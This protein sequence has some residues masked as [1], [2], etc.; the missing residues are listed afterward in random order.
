MTRPVTAGLEQEE[1]NPPVRAI[2]A[3]AKGEPAVLT[4]VES[5]TAAVGEVLVQVTHS[6][7]NYKDGAALLGRPGI[8]RTW[9][10]ILG[11]DAVGIVEESASD[12]FAVGDR[13]VLNGAGAGEI[14][15][16]GFAERLAAPAESLVHVPEGLSLSQAAAIGTAGFTAAIAVLAIEDHGTTPEDGEVLVT[17]AAGGVGSVAISLLAGRG[18]RVV[19]STGRAETEGDYLT[20]LGASRIIDR[21]G[22]SEPSRAPLG[23]RLWSAVVDGVGSHTLVN[24]VAQLTYGGIAVSYGLAQGADLPGTVMPFILRAATLTGANSVDAPLALRQRAWTMLGSQLDLA[25]LDKMTATVGLSDTLSLAGPI[26]A[27]QVRGRTV[28]DLSS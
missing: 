22:L 23:Q 5:P 12:R 25:A 2:V 19:A 15:D 4:E 14:R 20:G 1:G 18:F 10:L 26:T 7:L 13:V 27:G 9:P 8:A 11:I 28:V 16:G 17:G 6:S 3:P 24:A 21:R